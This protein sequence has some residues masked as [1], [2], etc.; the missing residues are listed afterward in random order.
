MTEIAGNGC[1]GSSDV[2]GCILQLPNFYYFS[3][4][5]TPTL[6]NLLQLPIG[7]LE[8]TAEHRTMKFLRPIETAFRKAGLSTTV[9][10]GVLAFDTGDSRRLLGEREHKTPD[11]LGFLREKEPL[12][13][14]EKTFQKALDSLAGPCYTGGVFR[15]LKVILNRSA[16]WAPCL[17]SGL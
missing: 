13:K 1:F 2:E 7:T 8:P 5:P 9:F 14:F 11:L 16:V 12:K 10:S 6:P 17:S 4:S 3:N 15:T